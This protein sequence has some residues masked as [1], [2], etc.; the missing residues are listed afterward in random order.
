MT[1]SG[2]P[3]YDARSI[4]PPPSRSSPAPRP[5]RLS[6]PRSSDEPVDVLVADERI[7][8]AGAED[9][10]DARQR[11]VAPTGSRA[12]IEVDG[13]RHS[14]SRRIRRCRHRCRPDRSS[15][16]ARPSSVSSPSAP[17][18]RFGP[19]LPTSAVVVAGTR[20]VLERR[21][22]VAAPAGRSA[23]GQRLASI[24]AGA[25]ANVTVSNVPAPP[26]RTSLPA[27]PLMV[28]SPARAV[29]AR[30]R[31]RRR[32][33]CRRS[34]SRSGSRGRARS[35]VSAPQPLTRCPRPGLR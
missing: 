5:L 21:Q 9:V 35:M 30:S 25:P 17:E 10:L 8:A 33:G 6:L 31:Y 18:S 13:D 3:A 16:P 1:S 14:G 11:V 32:R 27:R 19:L 24:A 2:A 23:A 29:D 15:S 22:V 7:V 26:M 34:P 20:H 4:P 28:S 12:G